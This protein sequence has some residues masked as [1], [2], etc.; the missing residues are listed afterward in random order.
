MLNSVEISVARKQTAPPTDVRFDKNGGTH[1]FDTFLL[2]HLCTINLPVP[3]AN[4][5]RK[6]TIL[7]S[8]IET[9]VK[10]VGCLLCA[11]WLANIGPSLKSRRHVNHSSWATAKA[12]WQNFNAAQFGPTVISGATRRHCRPPCDGPGSGRVISGHM[13]ETARRTTFVLRTDWCHN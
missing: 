2:S 3:W 10:R 4:V 7:N 6:E 9:A 11:C 12:L 8:R 13:W 1:V 5:H